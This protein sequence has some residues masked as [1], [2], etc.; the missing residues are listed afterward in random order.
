MTCLF[1]EQANLSALHGA[2]TS[3][4]AGIVKGD[5]LVVTF[6]GFGSFTARRRT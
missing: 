6:S 2:L 1:D 5:R 3:L 4:V